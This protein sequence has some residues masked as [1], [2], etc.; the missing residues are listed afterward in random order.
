[1]KFKA[2]CLGK[3]RKDGKLNPPYGKKIYSLTHVIMNLKPF[4]E[5]QVTII[6]IL[7]ATLFSL[8]P[9]LGVF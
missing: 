8:I 1:V 7:I 3:L 9:F 2:S 6:M 5:K 4:T